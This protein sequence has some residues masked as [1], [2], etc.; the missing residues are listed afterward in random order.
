MR[1][2]ILLFDE[3]QFK[4]QYRFDHVHWMKRDALF[5]D[6]SRFFELAT[7]AQHV[8]EQNLIPSF[9]RKVVFAAVSKVQA[10][11]PSA[12]LRELYPKGADD[13]TFVT[14]YFAEAEA[15]L[16]SFTEAPKTIPLL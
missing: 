3:L 13:E 8:R 15:T 11:E 10:F 16:S 7:S 9:V 12:K 14:F 5:R 4:A 2:C 6:L 1:F